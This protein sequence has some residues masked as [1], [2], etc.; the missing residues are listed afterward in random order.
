MKVKTLTIVVKWILWSLLL[1]FTVIWILGI[2]FP[3]EPEPITVLLG[4]SVGAVTAL[5][6]KYENVIDEEKYSVAHVLAQ[7]YVKNFVEPVITQL[8]KDN[9]GKKIQFYIFV[10][11]I[12]SELTP[13]SIDRWKSQLIEKGFKPNTLKVKLS[14]GRGFRDVLTVSNSDSRHVYFDFPTTLYSLTNFVEYKFSSPKDSLNIK[15][16][17]ELGREYIRQFQE[18]LIAELQELRLY[19]DVVKLADCDLKIEF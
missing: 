18:Q 12:L 8:Q 7:G 19:P 5:A 6:K 2:D 16:K 4:F 14:E 10:P 1:A 3:Y 9:P 17:N 11:G 13:K 15:G